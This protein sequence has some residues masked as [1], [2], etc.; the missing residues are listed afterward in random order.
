[1]LDEKISNICNSIKSYQ[2]SKL[3]YEN[4]N[5]F[6]QNETNNLVSCLSKVNTL[7][8]K[9][10]NIFTKLNDYKNYYNIFCQNLNSCNIFYKNFNDKVNQIKN[11]SNLVENNDLSNLN[12][13]SEISNLTS[14]DGI[15]NFIPKYYCEP[16]I[17]EAEIMNNGKKVCPGDIGFSK[18]PNGDE[19]WKCTL[20]NN[21][22]KCI[23]S[24]YPKG[25]T[26][27]PK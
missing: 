15:C 16:L 4:L 3:D 1:M 25:T 8:E 18:T 23:C 26:E 2:S 6:S 14:M 10:E 12:L 13:K 27:Y 5:C 9:R 22:N 20:K 17:G 19:N 24:L 11:E 7:A 21:E